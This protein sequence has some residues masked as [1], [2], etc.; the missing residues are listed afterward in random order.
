MSYVV[1]IAAPPIP[2]LRGLHEG[3]R[4]GSKYGKLDLNLTVSIDSL[5]IYLKLGPQRTT[6]N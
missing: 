2:E 3:G 4:Y 6:K 1:F 5:Y